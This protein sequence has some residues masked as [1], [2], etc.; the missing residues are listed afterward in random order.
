M[1]Q[2]TNPVFALLPE[3]ARAVITT[4]TTDK[5]GATT[6]NLVEL[7][8][9]AADGTKVTRI[10]YKHVGTSTA[11]V[12]MVFITDTSG[13]NLR[14]YDEQIYSAVT[15]SN[16]VATAGGILIYADLQLKSGQKIFVGST[17]ANTNIHAFASKGDF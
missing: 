6:T 14:L 5:S 11:G 8:A 7:V 10:S 9:A 4:A 12:F 3:T 2:N 17:T 16:T 1:A 13:A 15:S